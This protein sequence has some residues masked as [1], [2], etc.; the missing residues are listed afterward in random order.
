MNELKQIIA[1]HGLTA[2]EAAQRMGVQR[3]MV[4]RYL[5][6]TNDV[7]PER[8]ELLKESLGLTLATK[9]HQRLLQAAYAAQG[10]GYSV[11]IC[12]G[13]IPNG[14]EYEPQ[15]SVSAFEMG[16]QYRKAL[17]AI[18]LPINLAINELESLPCLV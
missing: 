18:N 10:K 6:G 8:L 9:Q 12:F 11:T 13:F 14:K 2:I 7:P 17:D 15:A 5:N 4:F 1:K 3:A 16:G